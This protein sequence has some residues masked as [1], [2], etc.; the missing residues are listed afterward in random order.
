[1][2][3]FRSLTSAR[4]AVWIFVAAI[5]I[6]YALLPFVV[7]LLL[8]PNPYFLELA[9]LTAVSCVCIVVGYRI[10]LFD[11]RFDRGAPRLA[12]GA[13]ML[14][15][16]IW[17]AFGAFLVVTFATADAIPIVSAIR[18]ADTAELSQQR[19]DFLKARS[20]A[21][22][23]LLYLS[24]L[25]V[26]ALLPYSLAK[27]FMDRSRYRFVLAAVFLGF[28]ISFLAK[29][30]FVNVMLPLLYVFAHQKRANGARLLMVLGG[31]GA[32]LY[33]VTVLAFGGQ[34]GFESTG[35]AAAGDFFGSGY[36]PTGAVD[37][38][39]WRAL[40]VPMFT[41]SDTLLVFAER[42][43]GNLLWGAT[44]SFLAAIFGQE[45]IPLEKLV[46]EQQWSWNDIASSNAVYIT[47]AYVNF[48]WP[49]VATFSLFVGQS[50]RWFRKSRDE[51]FKAL[52]MIYCLAIF[53]SSLIGTM[54]SN[55][56]VLMFAIALFVQI[57]TKPRRP[58]VSGHRTNT[59]PHHALQI[60]SNEP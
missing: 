10:P 41:A 35:L 13:D 6:V 43:D 57:G 59:S 25:F 31:S 47:E 4:V 17:C 54:L 55:G 53:T 8:L 36:L 49:G 45:R 32:L 51:A 52:W 24:T 27:L 22:V 28:S 23:A 30:L 38:L 7:N 12:I 29:A 2:P 3:S 48:G 46:F 56:Y 18:G 34:S 5:F 16:G 26:S 37:H 39:I 11:H 50:L 9:G 19:G 1:M 42:F 20:G 14:H 40:A 60:P 15:V 21:E 33:V 58:R 44:S